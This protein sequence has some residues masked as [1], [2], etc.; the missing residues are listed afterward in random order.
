MDS[1]EPRLQGT[2]C[3]ILIPRK[4]TYQKAYHVTHSPFSR[5]QTIHI[6]HIIL[7]CS[8]TA[9]L[10][11][12]DFFY[13]HHCMVKNLFIPH[14]AH[15]YPLVGASRL[16]IPLHNNTPR[17]DHFVVV[18]FIPPAR[19][20]NK[21]RCIRL[22]SIECFI[23]GRSVLRDKGEVLS[24][25]CCFLEYL[26]HRLYCHALTAH[27]TRKAVN[28]FS[29]IMHERDCVPHIYSLHLAQKRVWNDSLTSGP[30]G[31]Y[32]GGLSNL[33]WKVVEMEA[34]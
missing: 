7:A 24:T 6:I 14:I 27:L 32:R 17:P 18:S 34:V 12:C 19:N 2:C 8:Q 28:R 30:A 20:C 5:L 31:K 4:A 22:Q 29:S 21:A 33:S 3:L 26:V 15:S 1:P 10:Y 11:Q 9:F 16:H 25:I 23:A 13:I